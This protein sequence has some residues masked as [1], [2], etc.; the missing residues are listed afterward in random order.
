[1]EQRNVTKGTISA[2][3][4]ITLIEQF[5]ACNILVTLLASNKGTDQNIQMNWSFVLYAFNVDCL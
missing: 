4:V 3:I 2:G 5:M 1:M